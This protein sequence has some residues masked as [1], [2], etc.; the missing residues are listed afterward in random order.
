[1]SLIIWKEKVRVCLFWLQCLDCREMIWSLELINKKV[2]CLECSNS[3]CAFQTY[4]DELVLTRGK[5]QNNPTDF[6]FTTTET[7][8]DEFLIHGVV[9]YLV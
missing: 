4:E 8:I 6:L 2:E 9:T 3:N 1:M 5:L 7:L